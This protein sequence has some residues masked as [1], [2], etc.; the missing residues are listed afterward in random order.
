MYIICVKKIGNI[1]TNSKKNT[2]GNIF[3][4]VKSYDEII[5]DIPTLVIG[6][7]NARKCI[8][9]FNILHKRYGDIWWTFKKTERNCEYEDDILNF[10]SYSI[11]HELE[12][13]KYIYIDP[14][15]FSL[16]SIKKTIRFLKDK[17]K[18]YVFL[19]RGSHFMFIYSEKYN[20]VFGISL[21]MCEYLGINKQKVIKLVKN[22]EFI[23]DTK[24]ITTEIRDV[25]GQNTH[26]I[27]P[28]YTYFKQ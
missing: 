21:E 3:N 22:G 23:R 19:T 8:Q 16:T 6:V 12:K 7:E 14:I 27:L 4:V 26:Y 9:G 24:F 28:L 1:V 15:R 13:T 18:K 2:F 5:E 11:M 17:A 20:T 10:Y 25:I